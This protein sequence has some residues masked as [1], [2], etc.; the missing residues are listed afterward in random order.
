MAVVGHKLM[1]QRES[2]QSKKRFGYTERHRIAHA[3]YLSLTPL[4]SKDI[5]TKWDILPSE[6]HLKVCLECIINLIDELHLYFIIS[7][8][9]I[10]NNWNIIWLKKEQVALFNQH[11]DMKTQG[12]KSY[13]HKVAQPSQHNT[14]TNTLSNTVLNYVFAYIFVL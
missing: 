2:K 10:F 4:L 9:F 14:R 6:P 5:S 7:L 12:Q 8:F 11:W 3:Q 1:T 13:E